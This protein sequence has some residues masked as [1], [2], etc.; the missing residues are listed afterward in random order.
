MDSIDTRLGIPNVC[1]KVKNAFAS[2]LGEGGGGGLKEGLATAYDDSG[3]DAMK[4]KLFCN[5]VA[6]S[7]AAS[8]DKGD[9]AGKAIN[10]ER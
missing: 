2:G 5:C 3:G 1:C 4:E 6:Y 7:T 9:F 10:S 8:G